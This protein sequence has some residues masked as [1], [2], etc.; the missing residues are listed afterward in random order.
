MKKTTTA[1][2]IFVFLTGIAAVITHADEP[3]SM[4]KPMQFP[5]AGVTLS[6]PGGF[7]LQQ[8]E[9]EM[10]VMTATRIE[11][12]RATVSISLQ[13]TPV[14]EGVTAKEFS[15]EQIDSYKQS[16]AVRH[17]KQLKE[18][19]I[20]IAPGI[21]GI[22]SSFQYSFRGIQTVAVGVCFIREITPEKN[23]KPLVRIAYV[24]TMEMAAEQKKDL[25]L[26]PF[27]RPIDLDHDYKGPLL[28]DFESGY[29]IR[30]PKGWAGYG[31]QWGITL[32]QL[33][34]LLGGVP[35][36]DVQVVSIVL[37]DNLDSKQ[38]GRK[39][40]DAEIKRGLK[41]DVLSE[42]ATKLAGKDGYQY[43]LL[44]SIPAPTTKPT[45]PPTSKPTTETPEEEPP[46]RQTPISEA[47]LQVHRLLSV[48]SD[49]GA[50]RHYA[51]ILTTRK[52]ETKKALEIMDNLVAGFELIA[53]PKKLPKAPPAKP[54]KL[55][56]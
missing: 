16:L 38:C 56:L 40:I 36:P 28:K 52:C 54:K 43:V 6:L 30:L 32:K 2:G 27:R 39:Y 31:N 22:A 41:V 45:T 24:L 20:N 3:I 37:S 19:P 53:I 25:K 34:F 23:E 49:D 51:I 7:E 1:I 21:E 11:S 13:A 4:Q 14:E 47:I 10:Q 33:D 26:T 17:F 50:V 48:P 15:Q 8:L 42:G 35:C 9:D 5:R 55:E 29:A 46:I 44:K 18:V 12:K